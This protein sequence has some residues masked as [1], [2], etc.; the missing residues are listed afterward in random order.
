MLPIIVGWEEVPLPG[1][2]R[3]IVFTT[4]K[5]VCAIYLNAKSLNALR[6][7]D[8]SCGV[9]LT[10]HR[11]ITHHA[12]VL[13]SL[14]EYARGWR[15]T[16][17]IPLHFLAGTPF[18]R[19]VWQTLQKIPYGHQVS[20]QWV[21]HQVGKPKAT[22]AVGNAVGKNPIPIL[23]PCHRV[24]RKDGSIGGFSAGLPLKRALIS[25]EKANQPRE[26]RGEIH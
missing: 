19:S 10:F 23:V 12:S 8:K 13:P 1:I 6:D 17:D 22:R 26:N 5:G 24:I 14:Q 18:Q 21:A 9:S 2:G 7:M 16:F 11:G 3:G 15:T 4:E 20:Y 25:I